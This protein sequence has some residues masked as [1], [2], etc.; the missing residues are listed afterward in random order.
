MDRK[1]FEN[2]QKIP[3]ENCNNCCIFAYFAKK[4][5]NQALNFRAFGRKTQ[6]V[7]EILRIFDENSIEKLNFYLF[8]GKFVAKNRNSEITSFSYNNFFL[9]GGG[10][11]NPPCVRH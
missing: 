9:F 6:L 1:I 3:E 4:L 2:L 7:G 10:S 8:F 5:Q 11:L